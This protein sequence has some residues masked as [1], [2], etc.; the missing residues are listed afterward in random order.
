MRQCYLAGKYTHPTDEGTRAHIRSAL[1]YAHALAAAGW[2]PIVP[3]TMGPHRT[4]WDEAMFR[5]RELIRGLDPKIDV[6]VALPGWT[7]SRGAREEVALAVMKD[8]P[9]LTILQAMEGAK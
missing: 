8:I 4:S 3:H 5:C 9:V 1:G 7:E 6:L 2:H